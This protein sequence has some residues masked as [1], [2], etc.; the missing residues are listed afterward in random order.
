MYFDMNIINQ[1]YYTAKRI[2]TDVKPVLTKLITFIVIILILGSAFSEAFKASDLDTVKIVYYSDDTGVNGEEFIHRLTEIKSIKSLVELK[3]ISSFKDAKEMVKNDKAEAFIYI[4]KEFS[5][6]V[7]NQEDSNIVEVYQKKHSGVNAAIV[8]NVMDSF[9]NGV[10]TAGIVYKMTG[11]LDNYNFGTDNGLQ[12]ESLSDSKTPTAMGYYA[13]A[14]LLM[15]L[16]YG[17]EYGRVYIGEDYLGTLGERIKI[18]PINPFWQYV[19]KIIGLSFVSLFQGVIIVLFTK[20]IYHVDWGNGFTGKGFLGNG[21]FLL[22]FI[23][24]TFSFLTTTFGAMLSIVTKD[25]IKAGSIVTFTT[26][27]F[28]FLAGGF[29]VMDFGTLQYLSPSYY[30]KTA[31]FNLVYQGDFNIAYQN[32]GIMW[33]ITIVIV[34]ISI[35]AA[36]RKRA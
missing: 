24:F 28:T 16:L 23:I 12:V 7:E 15:L 34:L 8:Q 6:Q 5:E 3:E 27:A 10:N 33:G 9:T 32:I 17:A 13:V 25:V 26:I 20:Y 36:G 21:I 14:M 1:I 35:L 30:A 18:A 11:S 31:I 29:V 2:I 22:L 19:G 4:P